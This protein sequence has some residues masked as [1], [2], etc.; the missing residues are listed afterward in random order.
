MLGRGLPPQH[1]RAGGRISRVPRGELVDV[2]CEGGL[3]VVVVDALVD[4]NDIPGRI[5]KPTAYGFIQRGARVNER[6][7]QS[8]YKYM[9]QAAAD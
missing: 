7:T 4:D 3:G 6:R 5:D 8:N 9:K 1:T 2:G